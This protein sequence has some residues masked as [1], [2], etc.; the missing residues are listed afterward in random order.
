MRNE[1]THMHE[2]I[3]I[4]RSYQFSNLQFV[5]QKDQTKHINNGDN[6]SEAHEIKITSDVWSRKRER[7]QQYLLFQHSVCVCHNNNNCYKQQHVTH[8]SLG[9]HINLFAF[10]LPPLYIVG[11]QASYVL[12]FFSFIFVVSHHN[13]YIFILRN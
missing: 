9:Y 7:H 13:I 4:Y 2:H 5:F 1:Y 10:L 12:H 8:V 11:N 6:I 3:Y